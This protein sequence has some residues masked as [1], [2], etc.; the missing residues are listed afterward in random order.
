MR[1]SLTRLLYTLN[2]LDK[3]DGVVISRLDL[4]N[5]ANLGSLTL[6]RAVQIGRILGLIEV[7]ES[8]KNGSRGR[9]PHWYKVVAN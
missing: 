5:E 3:G 6:H 1:D 7:R 2:R 9:S 4:S 8:D